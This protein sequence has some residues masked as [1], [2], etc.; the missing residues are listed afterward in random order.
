LTLQ[1]TVETHMMLQ[2]S[3]VS[4]NK[5]RLQWL[6]YINIWSGVLVICAKKRTNG[7][8]EILPEWVNLFSERC[9]DFLYTAVVNSFR[10]KILLQQL[11]MKACFCSG[12][13]R[14]LDKGSLRNE[15]LYRKKPIFYKCPTKWGDDLKQN[16]FLG[17]FLPL[18]SLWCALS[19]FLQI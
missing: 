16:K 15:L 8:F 6:Q 4:L 17:P 19:T 1:K 10:V 9:I 7:Q 14:R 2:T 11:I 18:F 5:V 3:K 13:S 12:M